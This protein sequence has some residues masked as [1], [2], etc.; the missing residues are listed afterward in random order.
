[1]VS[2]FLRYLTFTEYNYPSPVPRMSFM[3]YLVSELKP[4]VTWGGR[5]SRHLYVSF[6]NVTSLLT[7]GSSWNEGNVL[8]LVQY[9]PSFSSYER[10]EKS[11]DI[12]LRQYKFYVSSS[13]YKRRPYY[14]I[15]L[16][17]LIDGTT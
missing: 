5:W 17:I 11:L 6:L 2:H 8:N 4:S 3:F 14:K 10:G 13:I 7:S 15:F 16:F 12:F 1:M 9:L